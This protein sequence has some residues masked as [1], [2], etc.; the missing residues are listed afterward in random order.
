MEIRLATSQDSFQISKLY[1]DIY[2]GT[3]PDPMMKSFS[4][5]ENFIKTAGHFWFICEDKGQIIASV[6]YLYDAEHDLAKVF[7]GVVREEYRGQHLTEKMMNFGLDYIKSNYG[8]V[9]LCYATTRTVHEGAQHLTENLGYKKLGIFPNVHKT[10]QYETHCLTALYDD[11]AFSKRFTDYK[12][13]HSVKSLVD[14]ACRELKIPTQESIIPQK[15]T[16]PLIAP[17]ILEYVDAKEFVRHRY[18]TL[19]KERELDFDFFPFNVPNV[20]VL[21][22]DQS[23]EIFMS[24]SSVDGHCLIVGGVVNENISYTLLFKKIS[25]L[26]RDHGI[27]YIE[28]LVRAD[29]P[30]ILESIM[31]SKF[32]PCAFLPAYLLKNG[33]RQDYLILSRTFEVFDFQN[34]QLRGINLRYLQE[35][36]K[37]WKHFALTPK[38]MNDPEEEET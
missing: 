14:I 5:I 16:R 22:P 31:A 3:Y 4:L 33:K 23:I 24:V 15:S 25:D 21:S 7:A 34:I 19:K 27:R 13:H 17:K 1:H 35:Y 10:M 30:K 8:P 2:E 36:F 12:I 6:L 9:E 29:K 26:L 20:L 32:I 37:T 18:E 11:Q 38:L 28:L